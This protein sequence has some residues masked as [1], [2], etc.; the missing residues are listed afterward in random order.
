MNGTSSPLRDSQRF[1]YLGTS[2]FLFLLIAAG[3]RQFF[4]HGQAYPGRPLTLEIRPLIILHGIAMTGW[5]LLFLTQPLLIV[6]RRRDLHRTMGRVGGILAAAICVL[7]PW[8][9]VAATKLSPP[10]FIFWG[11]NPKQFLVLPL[12]AI[13]FFAGFF[14]IGFWNRRRPAVHRPMMLLATL[15]VLPAATDRIDPLVNLYAESLLGAVFGPYLPLLLIGTVVLVVRYFASRSLD[16]WLAIGLGV[17]FVIGP[18]S[19]VFAKT[20][21]WDWIASTL[22]A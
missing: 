2:I 4:V 12:E 11:L 16:R 21:A 18:L 20:Q 14:A 19:L 13:A 17:I 5:I 6:K 15:S 1:L 7:G 9:A 8:L 3:F 22:L 10:D